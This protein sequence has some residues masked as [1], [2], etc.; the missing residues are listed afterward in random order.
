MRRAGKRTGKRTDGC[1]GDH[2]TRDRACSVE[3]D[4][5][6]RAGERAGGRRGA[7]L[8]KE[9]KALARWTDRQRGVTCEEEVGQRRRQKEE[10]KEKK[11][12]REKRKE[13]DRQ[14]R[15]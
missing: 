5:R 3:R 6:K 4:G 10:G 13:G 14:K 15:L 12:L 11:G 2:C 8:R 1:P 9:G 7:E